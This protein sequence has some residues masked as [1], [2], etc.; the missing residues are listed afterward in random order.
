MPWRQAGCH[1][2][3]VSR[4]W[5]MKG[6]PRRGHACATRAR[7]VCYSPLTPNMPTREAGFTF[8]WARGRGHATRGYATRHENM[9]LSSS[10]VLTIVAVV[11]IAGFW[12]CATAQH[13]PPTTGAPA[14]RGAPAVAVP[15]PPAN[16][17]DVPF[18]Y[19]PYENGTR[20]PP[21]TPAQ[22]E[23]VLKAAAPCRTV[24]RD[25]WFVQVLSSFQERDYLIE[26]RIVFTPDVQTPRLREGAVGRVWAEPGRCEPLSESSLS[27]YSQV[28]PPDKP[29]ASALESAPKDGPSF[30]I[31]SPRFSGQQLVAIM[32][33]FYDYATAFPEILNERIVR[34]STNRDGSVFILMGDETTG[35][36]VEIDRL[37]DGGYRVSGTGSWAL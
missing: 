31:Y 22:Q 27:Q 21:L 35:I 3:A 18:L 4:I 10:I 29:F 9:R 5:N 34:F 15:S 28:A 17:R 16:R 32:D 11:L 1:A 36:S 25:V 20:E 23:Q 7:R 37:P 6:R 14:A 12:G 30:P 19:L 2:H 24:T 8:E 33:A 13:H 26:A